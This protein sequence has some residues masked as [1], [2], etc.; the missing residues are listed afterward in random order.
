MTELDDEGKTIDVKQS[1]RKEVYDFVV[2]ELTDVI[3]SGNLSTDI[4]L[5]SI[6]STSKLESR[7]IFNK[8]AAQALLAR[9]Y[10]NAEVYSGTAQWQE[11]IAAADEVINSGLYSL[12]SSYAD[13]FSAK[14]TNNSEHIWVA[15]YDQPSGNKGMNF[16]VMTLHYLSQSTYD[17]KAQPWNGYTTLEEFYNLYTDDD[18]RKKNNLLWGVQSDDDGNPLLDAA[19][20]N[21]D[22]DGFKL[23]YT[24]AINELF[25]NAQRQGG[26]RLVKFQPEMGANEDMSNDY[27][28]LRYADVLLIKAEATARMSSNWSHPMTLMLVNQ[29]RDRAGV[30]AYTT[31][32]ADEFLAER[33]R[34]MIME[35][36][37][38]QDLIR[39]GK[40]GDAWWEKKAHN[41]AHL[42]LF[43]IPQAQIRASQTSKFKLT[44]NTGY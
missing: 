39:F 1:T 40:W 7:S 18:D 22:P 15:P 9:I 21:T 35:T 8:A 4:V 26:A 23:N 2:K 38:R 36:V 14:N 31:L 28:I 3:A 34:E 44:Q 33:G 32:T 16:T 42:S 12:S 30:S 41:K 27:T 43:P 19:V 29:V 11:A 17:L 10:L 37:R 25:P 20:E 24:P 13:V 6:K 5:D